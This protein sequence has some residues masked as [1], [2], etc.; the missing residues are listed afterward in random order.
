MT[1]S[2]TKTSSKGQVVIPQEIR[3]KLGLEKGTLLLAYTTGNRVILKKLSEPEKGVFLELS[4]PIRE[5]VS[6]LGIERK[7][8]VR[9]IREV[10]KG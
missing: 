2:V 3:E 4:E 8:V 6:E 1:L 5:K 10:R 9:A 7:D